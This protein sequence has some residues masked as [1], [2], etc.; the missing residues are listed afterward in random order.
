MLVKSAVWLHLIHNEHIT[1]LRSVT[2]KHIDMVTVHTLRATDITIVILHRHFPAIAG[3][4]GA[5]TH[6]PLR[7]LNTYTVAIDPAVL[8]LIVPRFLLRRCRLPA[9]NNIG[10]I[11]LIDIPAG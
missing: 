2:Q 11:S 9:I 4:V 5:T 8:L 1:H 6:T 7:I 3:S 10:L